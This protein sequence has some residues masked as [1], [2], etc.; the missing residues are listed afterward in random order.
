MVTNKQVCD[1]LL[2]DSGTAELTPAE[3]RGVLFEV[4]RGHLDERAARPAIRALN[5]I[6]RAAYPPLTVATERRNLR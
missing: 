5:R 1:P 2:T 6:M 4:A 3:I